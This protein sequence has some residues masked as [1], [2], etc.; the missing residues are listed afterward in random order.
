MF[1]N[2][3]FCFLYQ[4]RNYF[5]LCVNFKRIEV[6]LRKASL[7][8]RLINGLEKVGGKNVPTRILTAS[9]MKIFFL[10]STFLN[11][12]AFLETFEKQRI[13][14]RIY[15]CETEKIYESFWK[16]NLAGCDLETVDR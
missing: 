15:V 6:L 9:E 16:T 14:I 2:C 3:R 5:L 13:S 7:C 8:E 12:C 4:W 11:A 1:K 10:C